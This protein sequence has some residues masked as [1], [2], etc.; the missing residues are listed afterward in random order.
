MIKR[1]NAQ[2][3]VEFTGLKSGKIEST[4]AGFKAVTS[5]V[6]HVLDEMDLPRALTVLN[7]MNQKDGFDCSGCAWPDPDGKR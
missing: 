2:P 6:A 5:A 3:P 4:A 7:N 1:T